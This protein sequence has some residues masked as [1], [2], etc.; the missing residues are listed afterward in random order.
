MVKQDWI[1]EHC[2]TTQP[3]FSTFSYEDIRWK[4]SMPH[5]P[6]RSSL[7]GKSHRC[8]ISTNYFFSFFSI[9]STNY[10]THEQMKIIRKFLLG[11][12][13]L[14]GPHIILLYAFM[15]VRMY[16]RLIIFMSFSLISE[17]WNLNVKHFFPC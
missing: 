9:T 5:S 3:L 15:Q 16:G 2:V 10:K 11:M 13:D 17:T 1:I 12:Q 4:I 7:I 8:I 6:H 14:C